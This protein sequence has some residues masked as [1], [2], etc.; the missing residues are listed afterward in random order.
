MRRAIVG[1]FLLCFGIASAAGADPVALRTRSVTPD[2][3]SG[4]RDVDRSGDRFSAASAAHGGF[5]SAFTV[6][7]GLSM[8]ER[9]SFVPVRDWRGFVT[10][11]DARE[12]GHQSGRF[13]II[14][15]PIV[16]PATQH[17]TTPVTVASLLLLVAQ[18]SGRTTLFGQ[19]ISAPGPGS[20][21][22]EGI[23]RGRFPNASHLLEFGPAATPSAT[24]EPASLLLLT[25]GV[26]PLVLRRRRQH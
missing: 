11:G 15:A 4:R 25:T 5:A 9:P 21:P 24:P 1:L 20:L 22:L 16:S 2:S 6:P 18:P 3:D 8:S 23:G 10:P 26:L 19:E 7:A 12:D 14:T 17:L 13:Q